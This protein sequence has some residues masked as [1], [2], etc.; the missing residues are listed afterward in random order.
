LSEFDDG[1]GDAQS[2]RGVARY[3]WRGTKIAS[4]W[5][6]AIINQRHDPVESPVQ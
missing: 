3:R 6:T 1:G 4:P 5:P 2:T